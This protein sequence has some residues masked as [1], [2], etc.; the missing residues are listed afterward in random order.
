MWSQPACLYVVVKA[1]FRASWCGAI[2]AHLNR[3]FPN[4]LI[5][6]NEIKLSNN[7]LDNFEAFLGRFAMRR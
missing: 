5:F 7:I 2:R 3:A 6:A 1:V 4:S